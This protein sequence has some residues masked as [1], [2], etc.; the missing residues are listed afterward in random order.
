MRNYY[1]RN[2]DKTKNYYQANSDQLRKKARDY[3][4]THREEI[5]AKEKT[6]EHRTK[7]RERVRSKYQQ[8]ERHL[9]AVAIKKYHKSSEYRSWQ[10]AC[11]SRRAMERRCLE[12]MATP[13]WVDRIAIFKI[14]QEASNRTLVT[15]IP[16]EVDHI[17]PLKGK[18][19]LGLNVPWNLQILTKKENREKHNKR[20]M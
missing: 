16:H 4:S 11:A 8:S 13:K 3:Y 6:P 10:R 18:G 2:P 7:N 19:F 15:G 9:N 17:W 14:Y 12:I 5:L 20:P 1:L